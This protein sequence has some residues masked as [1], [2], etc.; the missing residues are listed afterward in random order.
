MFGYPW[1]G[2]AEIDRTVKLARELM[3]RG[4]AHSLQVTLVI[5]YPG[6]PLFKDCE[7]QKLL[8]TLDW[9]NYDMRQAIMKSGVSEKEIKAAIRKVYRSY[10]HLSSLWYRLVHIRRFLDDFRYY[11]RGL[12]RIAGHLRDFGR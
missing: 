12:F 10:F 2:P 3:L 7:E 4:F 11:W 1:E 6:T 5:P 9:D 8:T